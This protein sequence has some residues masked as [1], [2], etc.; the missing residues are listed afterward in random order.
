MALIKPNDKEKSDTLPL[1]VVVIGVGYVGLVSAVCLAELGHSVLCLDVDQEKI[2]RLSLGQIPIYEPGIETLLQK[3][4]EN[5]H[6]RF[7][8]S[9]R[10]V[11]QEQNIDSHL[12]II[13]AVDTPTGQ[14]GR[15][16][17]SRVYSVIKSISTYIQSDCTIIMKSTV[18]IGTNRKIESLIQ[19]ELQA[20]SKDTLYQI[21][22]VS[23]PE[24]LREGAALHD[25]MHADRVI[26]G[27]RSQNAEKIMRTLYQPLLEESSTTSFLVMDP[28]SSELTKY[29]GNT[30]LALR[31]SF[32]NW[33]SR[34]AEMGGADIELI[35]EGIGSDR[36]IGSAFL[37]SGLGFGGSCFPKDI[38]ALQHIALDFG[39]DASLIEAI[40]NIN[41]SQR[42][43][44][45]ELVVQRVQKDQDHIR[46]KIGI[47]GLSFKPNTDDMRDAPSLDIIEYFLKQ[48]LEVSVFD[49][50]AMDNA[51]KILSSYSWYDPQYIHWANDPLDAAADTD[52]LLLVTE[53][54]IFRLID[55]L[56]LKDTM[57]E[58]L[59]FDGRNF[60]EPQEIRKQGFAYYSIG[61]PLEEENTLSFN[62]DSVLKIG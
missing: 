1:N 11:F 3:N 16:D 52:A 29:A 28:E 48:G 54:D 39:I 32:M 57:K 21:N 36:R 40:Q 51:K 56:K 59:I 37:R 61:R 18:P 9:Y 24:F 22:I 35:R 14:D 19:K 27:V 30:M 10:E 38:K 13:I 5:K 25:F 49:P 45:A 26:V 34:I 62:L 53:W 31:I 50:I 42:M 2:A 43:R 33:L 46:K 15:C 44:F 47:W 17:L 7:T 6:L 60:F 55:M 8:H 41:T 23:N 4:I 20:L 12:T 58:P